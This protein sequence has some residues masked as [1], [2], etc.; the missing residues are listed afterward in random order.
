MA[1]GV[2]R[3]DAN[4]MVDLIQHAANEAMHAITRVAD[5]APPHLRASIMISATIGVH[6]MGKAMVEAAEQA[7]VKIINQG[8]V[9]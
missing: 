3:S 5:T 2:S 7:G 6:T 4:I 1:T 8:E 9:G